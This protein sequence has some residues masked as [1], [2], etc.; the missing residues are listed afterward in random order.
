MTDEIYFQKNFSR[1]RVH[2][3]LSL[4]RTPGGSQPGYFPIA[5]YK[6]YGEGNVFYTA[7]GH[8]DEMWMDPKFQQHL[9]GGIRWALGLEKGDAMPQAAKASN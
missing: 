2:M 6:K 3:L 4:D 5:W 8:T 1:D 9:L 7:L